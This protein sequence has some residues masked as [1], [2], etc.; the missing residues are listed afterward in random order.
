MTLEER[1]Q[2][3]HLED[4][5]CPLEATAQS[6]L[7]DWQYDLEVDSTSLAVWGIEILNELLDI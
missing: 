5:S 1:K 3:G 6:K 2:R 4:C 7:L